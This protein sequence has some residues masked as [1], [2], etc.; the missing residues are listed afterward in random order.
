MVRY[1]SP[2]LFLVIF[3]LPSTRAQL[4]YSLPTGDMS[5]PGVVVRL[6]GVTRYL[7]QALLLLPV[8]AGRLA[9]LAVRAERRLALHVAGRKVRSRAREVVR[10]RSKG[11]VVVLVLSMVG[12]LL[13]LRVG[14]ILMVSL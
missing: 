12:L 4:G 9:K 6:C 13:L 10:V 7:S 14:L 8:L 5:V 1:S 11:I 3:G 2:A